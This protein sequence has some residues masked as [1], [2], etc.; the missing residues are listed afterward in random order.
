MP[1]P[2]T[3]TTSKPQWKPDL[4]RDSFGKI[5]PGARLCASCG[6]RLCGSVQGIG[7]S[8]YFFDSNQEWCQSCLTAAQEMGGP[9]PPLPVTRIT[10]KDLAKGGGLEKAKAIHVAL[11]AVIERDKQS[12]REAKG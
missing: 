10:E 2:K 6:W 12:R 9:K 4:P 5:I 8:R 3:P 11:D 7:D 1:H